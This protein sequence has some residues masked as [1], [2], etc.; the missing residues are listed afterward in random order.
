MN[1][2]TNFIEEKV[3]P[4]VSKFSTNRYIIALRSGFLTIMPLTIIG[5]IFLLLTDFPING[6]S[7]FMA[8]I[9]GANWASYLE[10]AYRSTFN[11]M[12][13]LLAGTLA[14]KLAE[15]YKL[16]KIAVM[17]MSIVSFVIVT[18]KFATTQS[19]EIINKIL[20]MAWLGT[21]GVITA[22]IVGILTTEIYRIVIKM[23]LVIK[24]PESVPEM[25]SR[26]FSSLIPGTIVI[27]TMLLINGICVAL[28]STLHQVI[29]SLLQIPL[30]KLTS[31]I[32]AIAV[33]GGLNGL[34]WW[35]GIHP[36][37]VNSII[38]PVLNANSLEN[39][40]LFKAGKLT[41]ETGNIGTIQMIDQFATI[42]GAGMTIGLIIALLLVARSQKLKMLS[43][44]SAVPSMFNINEPLVFGVPIVMNPLMIIPVTVAPIVSVYLAYFAI[45]IGFMMPF[46]G[47][48][49]P[50]TTPPI[51]SGFLVSGWQ[52][53][54]VQIIA[55]A[56]SVL[57]YYPFVKALDNQYRKD[58][59]NL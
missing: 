43:R 36:T 56:A 15:Q 51:F 9:F 21:K 4:T 50:W 59:H 48:I 45:K 47:V 44:L 5:S 46:N 34:F 16:D 29:Y 26:S 17:I 38:N 55:I 23:N 27:A 18:P 2:F 3:V 28:G 30:Q 19:G 22:I 11:I 12:G 52:G 49:A 31:T 37:V 41:L 57:I 24:L 20:P 1:N 8:S 13:F 33:V 6:Y 32:G 42:G 40:E 53:A 14:Y 25:V 54:V 10:P 58:E 7:D 39:F 35:F